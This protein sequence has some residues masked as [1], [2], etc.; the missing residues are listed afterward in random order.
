MAIT[1]TTK[2]S[3][4]ETVY[5]YQPNPSFTNPTL[6]KTRVNGFVIKTI[7]GRVCIY[8]TLDFVRDEVLQSFVYPSV[9]KAKQAI[10]IEDDTE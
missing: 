2:Y 3:V 4:G 5:V 10:N 8:Y 6:M 1:I 7:S 9:E